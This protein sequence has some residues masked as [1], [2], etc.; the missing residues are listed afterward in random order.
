AVLPPEDACLCFRALPIAGDLS[1]RPLSP[2]VR[3]GFTV[4]S[5]PVCFVG[6]AVA[7]FFDSLLS[8]NRHSAPYEQL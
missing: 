4:S 2:S 6:D 5:L 8:G 7:H 1:Q 3:H